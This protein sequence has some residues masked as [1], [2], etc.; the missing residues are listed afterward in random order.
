MLGIDIHNIASVE[1]HIVRKMIVRNFSTHCV[2]VA[3][4]PHVNVKLIK[5]LATGEHGYGVARIYGVQARTLDCSP[6]LQRLV[7]CGM[8]V[9]FGQQPRKSLDVALDSSV[10]LKA[11]DEFQWSLSMQMLLN[12]SG[13]SLAS[14]GFPTKRQR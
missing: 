14:R 9:V 2:V 1:V 3:R 8:P 7:V 13:V 11:T 10:F 4:L 6:Y 12:E 5:V